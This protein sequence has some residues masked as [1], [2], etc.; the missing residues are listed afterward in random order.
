MFYYILGEKP[1]GAV[2][3]WFAFGIITIVKYG[4]IT[5]N[6]VFFKA[7]RAIGMTG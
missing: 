7:F 2:K 6:P 3:G 4:A 5:Y 1:C